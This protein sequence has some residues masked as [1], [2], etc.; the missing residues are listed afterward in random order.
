MAHLVCQH[1]AAGHVHHRGE[2]DEAA[3][4]RDVRCI[5]RPDLVRPVDGQLAQQVRVDP[6]ARRTFAGARLRRQ[7]LD[8]HALH[9][10]A[11]MAPPHHH[12][13]ALQLPAQ[14]ARAQEGVLKVQLVDAA[15]ERQIGR[16]GGRG[17]VVH[18]AAAHAQQ[19]RLARDRQRVVPVNHG[20]ALST[21]ASMSARSENHSLRKAG[22]SW[23]AAAPGPP[24][25]RLGCRRRGRRQPPQAVSASSL[26]SGWSAPRTPC[27]ARPSSYRHARQPGQPAP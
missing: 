11:D 5:Q 8:A 18:R 27:T 1:S 12:A 22:R 13:L 15:H 9:H 4:H 10:R 25:A 2:V 17:Q 23:R 7:R 14:H 16:A 6:V 24:A 3:R 20:F 19:M 26:R 21:P